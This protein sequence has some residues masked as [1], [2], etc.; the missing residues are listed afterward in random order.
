[1]TCIV[2]V[3]QDGRVVI[4]GDSAGVAGWSIT[5]RADTKVFRNGEFIMGFTDSFRMGQLLR[6]SLVPPV[7]QDWDL[8]RFMATDFIAVVRDCLREG[9]FAR[10]DSGNES[11]GLFLVGIRGHLYRI[12]SDYQIGRS[13]DDYYAVGSGDEYACG[14]L[15][16]TRGLDAEQRVQM[17]LEA[18]AH[19]STGV[20][21]PFH[22]VSSDDVYAPDGTVNA[23]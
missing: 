4:G 12:D 20:C 16:S 23:G 21:P 9:G 17:A 7:P 14:S 18:A 2:G 6:Y 11:G 13:V 8:D 3:Q 19:H 22:I 5:V 15:H 1:M 10:N